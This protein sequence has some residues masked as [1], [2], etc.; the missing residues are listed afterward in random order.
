MIVLARLKLGEF[1][2]GEL[3]ELGDS[4]QNPVA[5]AFMDKGW[6]L[7]DYWYGMAKGNKPVPLVDVIN[8][9]EPIDKI[10]EAYIAK[11]KGSKLAVPKNRLVSLEEAKRKK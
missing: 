1:I 8:W 11:I 3:L 10:A 6:G 7:T 4:I 9:T 2:I 5:I